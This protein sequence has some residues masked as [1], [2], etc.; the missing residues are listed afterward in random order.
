MFDG[1]LSI[2]GEFFLC[3]MIAPAGMLKIAH[4]QMKNKQ[5]LIKGGEKVLVVAGVFFIIFFILMGAG[6]S[7]LYTNPFFYLYGS[8]GV[9]GAVLG[10]LMILTGVKYN[11]YKSAVENHDLYE[12]KAIAKL[13]GLPE[14]T[15]INDLLRM[16]SNGFFPDLK[17]DMETQTLMLNDDALAM[18]ESK[19]VTCP[20]CNATVTVYKGR[21]NKCEYCGDALNY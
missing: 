4:R 15:V 18:L 17:F 20:A 19:A 1:L 13:M 11:K 6:G 8:A 3:M 9:L 10:T 7:E 12:A 14:S 5:E 21:R 16:I 2:I